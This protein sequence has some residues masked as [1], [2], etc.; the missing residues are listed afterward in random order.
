VSVPISVVETKEFARHAAAVWTD[1][2]RSAFVDWIARNPT[3]GDLIPGAGGLRKVRWR[4]E[5]TGKRSGAR[6]VY[7]YHGRTMPLY[8]LMVYAKAQRENM[9]HAGVQALARV[10]I[11]IKQQFR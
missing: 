8:L 2:E 11:A 1:D 6:V 10:V 9:D 4:R 3:A 7:F 5:G